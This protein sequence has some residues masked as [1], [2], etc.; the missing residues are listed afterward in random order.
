VGTAFSKEMKFV[1]RVAG[2]RRTGVLRVATRSRPDGTVLVQDV[3]VRRFRFVVMG[4][5]NE[6]RIVTTVN[7]LRLMAMGVRQNA[8]NPLAI[9]AFPDV[10]VFVR[11]VATGIEPRMKPATIRIPMLAMV[12]RQP[13]PS[14]RDTVA[15]RSVAGL[16]A[17]M[18]NLGG[19][20][21]V[22]TVM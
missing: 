1:T 4:H 16:C 15:Q 21:L 6:V 8:S 7:F 10:R 20:K 17:V 12:V 3:P 22:T 5:E 19:R 18:V 11:Y 14:S 13:V 2:T 9:S